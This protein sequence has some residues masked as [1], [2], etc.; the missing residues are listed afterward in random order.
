MP[1]NSQSRDGFT[2]LE[3]V[4]SIA[5]IGLLLSLLLPAVQSARESARQMTCGDNL[6]QLGLA[7]QGFESTRRKLPYT[8]T[9]WIDTSCSPPKWF[10]SRSPHRDLMAHLDASVFDAIDLADITSPVWSKRPPD[11]IALS[12]REVLASRIPSIACPSDD[13]PE[14]A[15]SYRAN[16]GISTEVLPPGGTVE[17]NSQM[18]A[19]VNG[20]SV[21]ITEFRDGTS[22][23]ALFSERVVGDWSPGGYDPFRDIFGRPVA[24][25]PTEQIVTYCTQQST[26]SPAEEFSFAGGNWLLGGWLNTWYQHVL[27][28]NST[29]PDCGDGSIAIDGGHVLVAARSMHPGIVNVAMADGSVRNVADTIDSQ[30]WRAMGTRAGSE[31]ASE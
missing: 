1:G 7:T 13:V 14:G 10:P 5:V 11:A 16:L 6:K 24:V 3:L 22:T 18:G 23:T 29:T 12:N 19:F 27:T 25:Y 31:S 20:R 21:R 17:A 30:I 2:V 15:T 28:P 8:S 9:A 4:A 26:S